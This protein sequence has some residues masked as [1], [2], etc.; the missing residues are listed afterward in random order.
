MQRRRGE[1][2]DGGPRERSKAWEQTL[3]GSVDDKCLAVNVHEGLRTF[4]YGGV[5]YKC[6]SSYIKRVASATNV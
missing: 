5:T 3:P 2:A 4:I 1:A 6:I